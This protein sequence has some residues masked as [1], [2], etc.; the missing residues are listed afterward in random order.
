M[1]DRAFDGNWRLPTLN[2]VVPGDS[3]LLPCVQPLQTFVAAPLRP[4]HV[5]QPTILTSI[6]KPQRPVNGSNIQHQELMKHLSTHTTRTLRDRPGPTRTL[7]ALRL[8]SRAAT[9]APYRSTTA[10]SAKSTASSS[11]RDPTPHP[12]PARATECLGYHHL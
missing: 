4:E 1:G 5:S 6:T 8:S 10:A 7:R 9:R 12:A 11:T 2:P 3:E